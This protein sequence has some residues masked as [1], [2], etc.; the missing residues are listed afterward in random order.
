MIHEIELPSIAPHRD[1][2]T[3]HP[4]LI[5]SFEYVMPVDLFLLQ[6]FWR[7]KEGEKPGS[8]DFKMAYQDRVLFTRIPGVDAAKGWLITQ[9]FR[10]DRP[11]VHIEMC[12]LREGETL[13]FK[14][15]HW[16]LEEAEHTAVTPTIVL[17]DGIPDKFGNTLKDFVRGGA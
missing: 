16:G 6:M 5:Q 17:S 7:W 8:L 14:F 9:H 13:R 10:L 4:S 1:R 3:H 15:S 12:T 11:P 2:P